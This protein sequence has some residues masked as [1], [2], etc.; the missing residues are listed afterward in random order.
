MF[1]FINSL[2]SDFP[3][4]R[5]GS[6]NSPSYYFLRKTRKKL[7]HKVQNTLP[8]NQ[9]DR[10]HDTGFCQ[11]MR[12]VPLIVVP[13]IVLVFTSYSTRLFLYTKQH[14]GNQFLSLTSFRYTC[15]LPGS[16]KMVGLYFIT[17]A[18]HL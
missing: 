4:F 15:N 7:A 10:I 3:L 18:A 8:I 11:I 12:P 14:V 1:F 5:L 13:L 9:G 6:F 2:N 17:S 16:V